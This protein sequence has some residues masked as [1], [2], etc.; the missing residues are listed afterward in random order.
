MKPRTMDDAIALRDKISLDYTS[1]K[2]ERKGFGT[3]EKTKPDYYEDKGYASLD[4]VVEAS[5]EKELLEE[6]NQLYRDEQESIKKS[7]LNSFISHGPQ[8][9]PEFKTV[10]FIVELHEGDYYEIEKPLSKAEVDGMMNQPSAR[11]LKREDDYEWESRSDS[12]RPGAGSIR[13]Y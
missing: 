3:T 9:D 13:H 8:E 6:L 2:I 1:R 11:D 12:F 5:E 4:F 10:R 7:G